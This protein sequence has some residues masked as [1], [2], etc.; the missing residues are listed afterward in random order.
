MISPSGIQLLFVFNFNLF[1]HAI[2]KASVN[3][4]NIL[5]VQNP[6]SFV[7]Y[8]IFFLNFKVK[9]SIWISFFFKYFNFRSMQTWNQI[10]RQK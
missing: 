7:Y 1:H 8:S 9:F 3:K 10:E 2:R 6:I 5:S 4:D